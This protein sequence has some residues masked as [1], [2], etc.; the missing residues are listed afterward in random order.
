MSTMSR[1]AQN[2]P[3]C[4]SATWIR[5]CGHTHHVVIYSKFHRNPLRGFGAP[6]G[7]NLS[8]PLLWLLAFTTAGTTAVI[9]RGISYFD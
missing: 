4:G 1:F 7:L 8:F 2:H 3:R 6:W 5:V 9:K